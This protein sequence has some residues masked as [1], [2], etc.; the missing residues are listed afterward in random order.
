MD[1]EKKLVLY[2][3]K[4]S[5]IIGH[6]LLHSV[7]CVHCAVPKYIVIVPIIIWS[8]GCT[9]SDLIDAE[10]IVGGGRMEVIQLLTLCGTSSVLRQVLQ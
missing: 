3:S 2:A 9:G 7:H 1:L 6:I 10:E 8:L 4:S 5:N